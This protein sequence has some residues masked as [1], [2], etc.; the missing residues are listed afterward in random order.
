MNENI[1]LDD[2]DRLKELFPES[3]QNKVSSYRNYTDEQMAII[4]ELWYYYEEVAG[5]YFKEFCRVE[6]RLV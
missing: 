2:S 4:E 1:G 5:E 3:A 6:V